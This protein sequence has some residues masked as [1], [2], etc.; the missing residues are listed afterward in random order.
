M[1]TPA[2]NSIETRRPIAPHVDC[3]LALIEMLDDP[4]VHCVM[5]RD[6]VRRTD[7]VALFGPL[8]RQWLCPAA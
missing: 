1:R 3:E 7:I 2:R 4:I 8:Q 5:R 6:G